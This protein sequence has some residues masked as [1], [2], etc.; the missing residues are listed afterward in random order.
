M[1]PQGVVD[2]R[3]LSRLS[4]VTI[5]LLA[6]VMAGA[7]ARFWGLAFGLPH[8]QA[9]P[10]ETF[11]I[12]TARDLL[13]G[14]V[15]HWFYDYPWLYMWMLSVLYVGYFLWGAAQGTFHSLADMVASWPT[16]WEPFFL[17]SRALSACFGTATIV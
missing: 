6:I 12:E 1:E 2:R 9:R 10:D 7:V 17:I 3:A 13:S 15:T 16:H 14:H 8:T 11:V 5:A 4:S